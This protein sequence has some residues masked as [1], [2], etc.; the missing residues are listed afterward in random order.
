MQSL[1]KKNS[2][3][4]NIMIAGLDVVGGRRFFPI[5]WRTTT[6]FFFDSKPFSYRKSAT[7][8]VPRGPLRL[9][10]WIPS[11]RTIP[12][13]VP[14]GMAWFLG[15]NSSLWWGFSSGWLGLFFWIIQEEN[16]SANWGIFMDIDGYSWIFYNYRLIAGWLYF[17]TKGTWRKHFR[18]I[19]S[20]ENH[21]MPTSSYGISQFCCFGELQQN[22]QRSST[23][24]NWMIIFWW[25]LSRP[26]ETDWKMNGNDDDMCAKL[27]FFYICTTTLERIASKSQFGS[28]ISSCIVK[29]RSNYI[30]EPVFFFELGRCLHWVN[31]GE[32]YWLESVYVLLAHLFGVLAEESNGLAWHLL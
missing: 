11:F 12:A 3:N 7:F 21:E 23:K 16:H 32:Q 20:V 10:F 25:I 29:I 9:T 19:L 5:L 31:P 22:F 1:W 28:P 24:L 26:H 6:F 13:S 14:Y 17:T 27:F 18:E 8:N 4:L 2:R 15:W 30:R